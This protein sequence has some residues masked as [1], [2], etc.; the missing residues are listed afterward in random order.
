MRKRFVPKSYKQK[1]FLKLNSLKQNQL[2][3]DQYVAEFKKLYLA[4][5]C[6]EE[7]EQKIAKILLGLNKSIAYAF[8]VH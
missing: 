5:G 7:D 6:K 8:E 4:C 3:I 1:L 2:S